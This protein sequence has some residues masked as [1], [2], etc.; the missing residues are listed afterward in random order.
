MKIGTRRSSKMYGLKSLNF[1]PPM[2]LRTIKMTIITAAEIAV[3]KYR[4]KFFHCDDVP[5]QTVC[6]GIPKFWRDGVHHTS[7]HA[8]HAGCRLRKEVFGEGRREHSRHERF[9]VS[10]SSLHERISR[11][12]R[13]SQ[14]T[15]QVY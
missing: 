1:G 2:C 15:F 12:P 6:S 14:L 5:C 3:R 9:P 4:P 7:I 10:N 11:L 8:P 13:R